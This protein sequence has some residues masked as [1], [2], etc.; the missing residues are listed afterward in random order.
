M[1]GRGALW[2]GGDRALDPAGGWYGGSPMG[3]CLLLSAATCVAL[4]AVF[5]GRAPLPG[6]LGCSGFQVGAAEWEPLSLHSACPRRV[7]WMD[8]SGF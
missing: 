4:S 2:V 3:G 7:V 1:A 5:R 6:G 8:V